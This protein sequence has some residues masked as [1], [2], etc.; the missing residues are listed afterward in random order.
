MLPSVKTLSVIEQRFLRGLFTVLAP[1]RRHLAPRTIQYL[2]RL[3]QTQNGL[4]MHVLLE[5]AQGDVV[6]DAKLDLLRH[7]PV[8]KLVS[9]QRKKV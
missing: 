1:S 4:I 3:V 8:F 6:V 2:E 7:E 5:T 9:L